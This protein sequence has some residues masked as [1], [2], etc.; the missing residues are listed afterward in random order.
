MKRGAAR[1]A[2]AVVLAVGLAGCRLHVSRLDLNREIT[3]ESFEWLVLGQHHR[4]DVLARLGPPDRALYTPTELVF[5]YLAARHRGS[6]L[7]F[8]VPSDVMPGPIDP[9][10]VLAVPRF[11]FDLFV[12]PPEFQPTTMERVARAGADAAV[13]AA[14]F[15]SGQDVVILRGRKLRVDHLRVVFD[16]ATLAAT[17]KALRLASGDYQQQSLA[18]QI[19]LLR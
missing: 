1:A 5:D 9:A 14:P 12:E 18:D 11:F 19:L 10:A 8:F 7:R 16:R 6:D 15:V 4:R 3:G 2:L 17:S 13:S